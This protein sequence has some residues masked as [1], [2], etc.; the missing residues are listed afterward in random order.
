MDAGG[1]LEA[2]ITWESKMA[3]REWDGFSA[4]PLAL[5]LHQFISCVQFHEFSS[6]VLFSGSF[7]GLRGRG[8]GGLPHAKSRPNKKPGIGN[9]PIN[10]ETGGEKKNIYKEGEATE[11]RITLT[12]SERKESRVVGGGRWGWREGG[13]GLG[14]IGQDSYR[15]FV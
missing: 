7:G 8:A 2:V 6:A 3:A 9:T 12:P 5:Q 1:F 11:G 13:P 15:F 4:G 10:G 14:R